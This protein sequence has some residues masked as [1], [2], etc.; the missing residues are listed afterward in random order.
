MSWPHSFVS[1]PWGSLVALPRNTN[2]H[3]RLTNRAGGWTRRAQTLFTIPSSVRA[4]ASS[5]QDDVSPGRIKLADALCASQLIM[6]P[7][8]IRRR[9]R[10]RTPSPESERALC[11]YH[12]QFAAERVSINHHAQVSP[13]LPTNGVANVGVTGLCSVLAMHSLAVRRC[14]A[15]VRT[16]KQA[17]AHDGPRRGDATLKLSCARDCEGVAAS[18][19]TS[20]L[21]FGLRRRCAQSPP[22]REGFGGARAQ[23][24]RSSLKT[25]PMTSQHY[26]CLSIPAHRAACH[27]RG[28]G[29]SVHDLPTGCVSSEAPLGRWRS[30][31]PVVGPTPSLCITPQIKLVPKWIFARRNG[32]GRVPP[33]RPAECGKAPSS[34]SIR[35]DVSRRVR[36]LVRPGPTS[37]VRVGHRQGPAAMRLLF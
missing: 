12:Q 16:S 34:C 19:S 32:P 21:E 31:F 5:G 17:H 14:H 2:L 20:W 13:I 33:S 25:Q 3:L 18:P 36:I 30:L 4:A 37:H 26:F 15:P 28:L 22:R 10:R 27:A 7:I 6:N 29:I 24:N 11:V 23:V 9:R 35:L 8:G 1:R